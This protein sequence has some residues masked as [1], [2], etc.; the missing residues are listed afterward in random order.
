MCINKIHS[1]IRGALL[2]LTLVFGAAQ[3]AVAQF[4][5]QSPQAPP[6]VNEGSLDTELYLLV[7][8]NQPPAE[9][10]IP[11]LLDPVVKQLRA[12]LP[13]KH[14][15][16]GATLLN[17]VKGGGR[18]SLTWVGGPLLSPGGSIGTYTPTLGNFSINRI[19]ILEE[20]GGNVIQFLNFSFGAR[21]PIQTGTNLAPTG[22]NSAPVIAYENTGVTTDVSVRADQPTVVGT[23]N[24]G[25]GDAIIVVI[26]ARRVPR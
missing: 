19:N 6:R 7:A 11:A 22:T 1:V 26:N 9:V 16:L 24:A 13:F 25:S 18:L 2:C 15:N 14:Y 21:I 12:T 23:L 17:R 10:K 20:D 3:L 8:S 5:T 4:P